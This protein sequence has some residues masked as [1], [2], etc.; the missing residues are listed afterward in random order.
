MAD[1]ND[2]ALEAALRELRAEYLAAAPARLGELW[3]ALDRV[4]NGDAEALSAL[5]VLAHRL[6]G[7]G[8]GY[9]MP[10]VST[11]ARAA[12][13]HCKALIAA[14]SPAGSADVSQLRVLIQGIADAFERAKP[15]G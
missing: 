2:P 3:S 9:G 11:A 7:S 15:P 5:R 6:A 10:D 12:D 14:A 4:Q 1:A 13:E 8:G